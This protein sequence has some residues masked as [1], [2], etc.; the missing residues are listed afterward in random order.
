MEYPQGQRWVLHLCQVLVLFGRTAISLHVLWFLDEPERAREAQ[1]HRGQFFSVSSPLARHERG[2]S[3]LA[4]L[5]VVLIVLG[6]KV[7]RRHVDLALGVCR[8]V[9]GRELAHDEERERNA[10]DGEGQ[11]D[12]VEVLDVAVVQVVC[13]R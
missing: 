5:D 10:E 11:A 8:V 6:E 3:A 9:L 2:A 7:T 12:I 13:E 1:C 4:H